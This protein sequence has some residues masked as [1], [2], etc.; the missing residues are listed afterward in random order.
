[1]FTSAIGFLEVDGQR[2]CAPV[3]VAAEKPKPKAEKKPKA[4][5]AA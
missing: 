3:V 1:M 4:K 5:K 2:F